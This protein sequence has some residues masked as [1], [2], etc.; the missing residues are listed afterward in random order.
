MLPTRLPHSSIQATCRHVPK[1]SFPLTSRRALSYTRPTLAATSIRLTSEDL[2]ATTP[3]AEKLRDTG[4]WRT[5]APSKATQP[6]FVE[7]QTK[8]RTRTSSVPK[9]PSVKGDKQRVHLVSDKLGD[10]IVSYIGPSLERHRGC[11][12]IDINPGAGL[13]S[14]KLNDLLQPRSHLLLEPEAELYTPFLKSLLQKSGTRLVPKSGILWKDL[15]SVL[16]PEYLPHQTQHP[17]GSEK[18][19]QRNDTLLV[20]A[21]FAFHPKKRF[22]MFDS[23]TLMVLH[24]FIESIATN[25]L[26]Q[27]YGLV[28]MLIWTR[29]DDKTRIL[30][31][32]MQRRGISAVLSELYCDH[33]REVCGTANG[34]PLWFKRETQLEKASSLWTA[35]RMRDAGTVMP[36]GRS[37]ESYREAVANLEQGIAI[38]PG[39]SVPSFDRPYHDVLSKLKEKNELAEGFDRHTDPRYKQMQRYQWRENWEVKRHLCLYEWQQRLDDIVEAKKSGRATPEEIRDME[40]A[41]HASMSR[42]GAKHMGEYITYRDNLHFMRQNPPVMHWDRRDIEPLAVLP[43]EFYPNIECCLLDLQPKAVHPLMREMGPNSNRAGDSFE[44]IMRSMLSIG[45]QPINKALAAL[46]PG[47]AEFIIPRWHSIRDSERGGIDVDSSHASLTPRMLNSAQWAELLDL[48]MQWPFRPSFVDL[49][50]RSQDE[51]T[52]HGADTDFGTTIDL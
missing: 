12:I 41:W 2:K 36:S 20:T 47:A 30:P 44:L 10:D 16:T 50:G 13:W 39:S 48:W 31:R 26:F 9:S 23:I 22:R 14:S 18:L 29:F 25:S 24:Q 38:V 17:R 8:R 19:Q 49:I 7:E 33:F 35:Q 4:I 15:L 34:D 40:A 45:T 52:V 3:L 51:G 1:T 27:S 11:D 43:D 28:R 42:N 32:F 21:N 6:D 5:R 37:N 46:W